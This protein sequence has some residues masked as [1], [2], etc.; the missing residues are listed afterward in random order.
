MGR[1]GARA[2]VS[3]VLFAGVSVASVLAAASARAQS[4]T[5]AQAYA[6]RFIGTADMSTS[7]RTLNPYGVNYADCLSDMVLQFPLALSGFSG[8]DN[9]QVWATYGADC[10]YG[11]RGLE[12]ATPTCWQVDPGLTLTSASTYTAKIPVRALVAPEDGSIPPAGTIEGD[13]GTE[14]CLHQQSFAGVPVTIWFLPTTST[15]DVD[16]AG[17]PLKYLTFTADLV[18]PPPP[19][20]LGI[21]DGDTTFTV[22]WTPN[23]DG[24]TQGYDV[25]VDPPS[26]THPEGGTSLSQQVLYCPDSGAAT[27]ADAADADASSA[28]DGSESSDAATSEDAASEAEAEAAA[29]DAASSDAMLAAETASAGTDA[30]T[31][32]ACVPVN[33]GGGASSATA[34]CTSTALTAPAVFTAGYVVET[35]D[36]GGDSGASTANGGIASLTCQYLQGGACSASTPAYANT[37]SPSV[38]GLSGS[39]LAITGLTN[40]YLYNV[41]VAAV[42]GSGNVGPQTPAEA[43]DQPEPINDF[44]KTYR[45]DGGSAGGGFCDL[46]AVGAP[47]GASIMSMGLGAVAFGLARRRRKGRR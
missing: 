38:T 18:G 39:S 45:L 32:D 46:E 30:S 11:G 35:D 28:D 23:N 16:P 34:G 20:G 43:C 37:G 6:E 40:G 21:Q 7:T 47:T 25:F 31:F 17:T 41:V 24:D 9:L 13:Q 29:A 5:L 27:V 19:S 42:D 1:V 10:Y 2:R 15:G 8:Q 22:S 12:G 33:A 26:G 44:Y 14:A 4:I 3:R 36:A